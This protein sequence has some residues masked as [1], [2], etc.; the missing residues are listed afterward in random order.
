LGEISAVQ[1]RDQGQK[2]NG[3]SKEANYLSPALSP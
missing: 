2:F 3:K 1:I